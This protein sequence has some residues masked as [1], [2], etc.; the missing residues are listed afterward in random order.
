MSLDEFEP[1][2]RGATD[3]EYNCWSTE[4]PTAAMSAPVADVKGCADVFE[5]VE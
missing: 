3:S 4:S 5:F 2:V 1:A